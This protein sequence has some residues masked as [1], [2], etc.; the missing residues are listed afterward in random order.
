MFALPLREK[1]K[2]SAMKYLNLECDNVE[3]EWNFSVG[4]LIKNQ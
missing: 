2:K 1:Y 3:L 4:A